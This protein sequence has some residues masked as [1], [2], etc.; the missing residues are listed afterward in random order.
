M[1][2]TVAFVGGDLLDGFDYVEAFHDFAE[3][4]VLAV[5][6]GRAA[7]R[8]IDF[9]HFRRQLDA[10]A[11]PIIEP[12]LDFV[13]AFIVENLAPD[14]VELHCRATLL[15]IHVVAFPGRGQD[16]PPVEDPFIEPKFGRNGIVPVAF[17][18]KLLPEYLEKAI[19]ALDALEPLVI[20]DEALSS[21]RK[22]TVFCAER[23]Q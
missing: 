14:N 3:D 7:D 15:R 17:A 20:D 1:E 2:G 13:E 12:L 18:E 10:A 4:G 19:M 9:P 11:G 22:L 8:L 6:V 16:A 23:N 5:E 21:L